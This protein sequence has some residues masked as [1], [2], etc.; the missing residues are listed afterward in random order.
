MTG[1]L[2][3]L[4]SAASGWLG[5]A[6]S[7]TCRG[8]R[9]RWAAVLLEATF[10]VA[11]G[12]GSVS[13]LF[14]ALLWAG[15]DARPAA[16][17]ALFLPATAS[18]LLFFLRKPVP[19]SDLP[20]PPD[21]RWS[22]LC[23]AAFVL[24]LAF[25]LAGFASVAEAN[26]QGDW[27]AWTIW[28]L[29]ARY[30]AAPAAWPNAVSPDLTRTHP[31]YPLLWSGV[32]GHAWAAGSD[33]GHPAVPLA[34]AVIVSAAAP[35][36]LAA[37]LAVLHSPAAGWLAALNLVSAA[38]WRRQSQALYADA[39][40]AF[41]LLAALAAALAQARNWHRPALALSGLL[42]ALAAWT[43]NEGLLFFV[44]CALAVAWAARRRAAAWLAGALPVA[45]LAAASKLCL[46][47]PARLFNPAFL[48]DLNR[49]FQVLKGL[50]AGAADL[51]NWAAHPLLLSA[52]LAAVIGFRRTL[53]SAWLL[54]PPLALLAGSAVVL[55]GTPNELIWQSN[56]TRERLLVQVLPAL[57]FAYCLLLRQPPPDAAPAAEPSR[58][59]RRK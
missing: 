58:P 35:L 55:W 16:W 3:L 32:I 45:L 7:G 12:L 8:L 53:D 52:L 25:F 56:S 59:R 29:R 4:L 28:N 43:K 23:A 39:P 21:W 5:V 38:A 27:D 18:A 17:S 42:A 15:L 22:R 2:V 1:V 6:A 19:S 44:F 30:L 26:P 33:S 24:A 47:P 20:T 34:T 36:L 11:A 37:A 49:A 57:L 31:H 48:A 41:F 50:A 54:A 9:P 46:A 40:L 14:F 51:A 10:G 13:A